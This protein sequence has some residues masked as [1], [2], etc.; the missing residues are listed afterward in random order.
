MNRITR[1]VWIAWLLTCAASAAGQATNA[2]GALL[3]RSGESA[4]E[5]RLH[6]D[7][8]EGHLGRGLQLQ[9][10]LYGFQHFRAP[11]GRAER[12]AGQLDPEDLS[13][14]GV[15]VG[16]LRRLV[17]VPYG[18]MQLDDVKAGPI[19]RRLGLD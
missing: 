18:R 11:Q 4:P 1:D 13:R 7:G 19:D 14:G 17:I 2:A 3:E 8:L 15:S 12:G 6:P 9:R 10:A 5:T 16:D